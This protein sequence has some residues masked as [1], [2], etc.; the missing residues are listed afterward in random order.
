MKGIGVVSVIEMT[1]TPAV[2]SDR[3]AISRPEPGPLTKTSTCR[4][5]CSMALRAADSAVTCAAYGV[6][7]RLPLNPFAPELDHEM[8][9]PAGSVMV[10]MVLLNVACTYALP[11][12]TFFRSR[13]R[14]RVLPFPPRRLSAM[15]D[16]YLRHGAT[17]ANR[18]GVSR[19]LL[20]LATTDCSTR[21]AP[22]SRVSSRSLHTRWHPSTMA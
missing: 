19:A 17:A 6:L 16:L 7:F 11:R 2:C 21:T 10:M 13:R 18:V 15:L 8:T 9:L 3:I 14:T 1:C 4:S 22:G 20:L 12:G 5:P